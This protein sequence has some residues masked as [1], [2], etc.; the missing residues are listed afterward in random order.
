MTKKDEQKVIVPKESEATNKNS[1][2]GENDPNWKRWWN[3]FFK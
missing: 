3:L 2:A 1:P